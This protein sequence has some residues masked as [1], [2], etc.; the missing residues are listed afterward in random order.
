MS[1]PGTCSMRSAISAL[2]QQLKA[3]ITCPR[4]IESNPFS[5]ETPSSVMRTDSDTPGFKSAEKLTSIQADDQTRKRKRTCSHCHRE[6]HTK[7]K[8]GKVS[9]PELLR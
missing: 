7:T 4:P 2:H 9:C 5:D 8:R 3:S 1:K 6:G